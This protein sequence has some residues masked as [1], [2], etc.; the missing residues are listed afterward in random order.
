MLEGED[1][2]KMFGID[3]DEKVFELKPPIGKLPIP[4]TVFDDPK[5]F[6]P[7]QLLHE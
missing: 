5:L 6:D 4:K 1:D 7:P 2:V 3:D